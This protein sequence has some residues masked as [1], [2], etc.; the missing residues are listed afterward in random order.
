MNGR[1]QNLIIGLVIP[2]VERDAALFLHAQFNYF[3]VAKCDTEPA[4]LG[5]A[6]YVV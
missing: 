2:C 5:I 3:P 1:V 6:I 4:K